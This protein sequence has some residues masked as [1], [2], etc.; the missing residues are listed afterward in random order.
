ML[1][2]FSAAAQPSCCCCCQL[3][4]GNKPPLPISREGLHR[5]P[6]LLLLLLRKG[7]SAAV[8]AEE[9][10]GSV[11]GLCVVWGDARLGLWSPFS[12]TVEFEPSN[13]QKVL[14]VR[15]SFSLVGQPGEET[16]PPAVGS[17]AVGFGLRLRPIPLPFRGFDVTNSEGLH[18]KEH[19]LLQ[20]GSPP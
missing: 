9:G 16:A 1:L 19:S 7:F 4:S 8:S 20:R 2:C 13:Q 12:S 3:Y 11:Q 10:L 14:S 5:S 15:C 18:L 17:S 6:P